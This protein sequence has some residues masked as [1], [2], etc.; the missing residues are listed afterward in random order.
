MNATPPTEPGFRIADW[1]IDPASG[2]VQCGSETRRLFAKSMAVLEYLAR[3]PGQ[4]VSAA[5]LKSNLW[6]GVVVTDGSVYQA[7]A[8]IRRALD[9]DAEPK[10]I[11]TIPRRGY[12]LDAPVSRAPRDEPTGVAADPE[13][14]GDARATGDTAAS[15]LPAAPVRRLWLRSAMLV[16][17]ALFAAV[18]LAAW[19][20]GRAARTPSY[21]VVVLPFTTREDDAAIQGIASSLT[22]EVL[23]ALSRMPGVHAPARHS[24]EAWQHE[25]RGVAALARAAP[26]RWAVEGELRR[27][28]DRIV[29][30]A[31]LSDMRRRTSVWQGSFA[32]AEGE[33]PLV[34]RAVSLAVAAQLP[35][36]S[37]DSR[38]AASMRLGTL[39]AVA[40]ERY[41]LGRHAQAKR[42]PD[43]IRRA[44]TLQ[45]Q[46]IALDPAFALAYAGLADAHLASRYYLARTVPDVA[47][48]VE[49]LL[50]RAFALDPRLPEL[51]A[52]RGVLRTEQFRL[53][54]AIADLTRAAELRPGDADILVRLGAALEYSGKP[55]E[56]LAPFDRA[57]S[58]DPLHFIVH[59]RRC[60]VLQN[61]GRYDDARSA[62]ER[63]MEI[64]PDLPNGHWT[65]GLLDL[66]RGDYDGA[67]RGYGA[68]LARA[69]TRS[70]LH[71]QRGVL[72]LDL[73][74]VAEAR[75]AFERAM[76]AAQP[77]DAYPRLA[78]ARLHVATGNSAGLMEHLRTM[79]L[80]GMAS[81]GDRIDA[82]FLAS[83][84]GDPAPGRQV[85]TEALQD[86]VAAD[87]LT[88]VWSTRWGHADLL[89]LAV[90]AR[91]HGREADGTALASALLVRLEKLESNGHVWHGLHY[92]KAGALAMTG[93]TAE[94]LAELE[95][96]RRLGYRRAWWAARDPALESLRAS[97]EH[98]AWRAR[99][100]ADVRRESE[101]LGALDAS[102]G[103]A[104]AARPA[105]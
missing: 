37:E 96:A 105:R 34:S 88:D 77:G 44:I 52:A 100:E 47:R 26:T 79:P 39:N 10:V 90:L 60:L 51:Y 50:T 3:R 33:L 20:A 62:C 31:R 45:E 83:L 38:R 2:T 12:R 97:A 98:A 13:Q 99:L 81:L 104:R 95:A 76:A 48:S 29:V 14:Q 21:G 87:R 57:A 24:V 28:G 6:R 23:S 85:L 70:D 82:A 17:A 103:L 55:R 8:D 80:D 43:A 16:G 91:D 92:L 64:E 56:A 93:A 101:V 35:S 72:L 73:G 25:H 84:A 19:N 102:Q 61:L 15:A 46:A 9:D 42:T 69:P 41:L 36:G 5:E 59:V 54:E 89:S 65:L 4:V 32:S 67:L 1:V 53:D 78:A 86:E 30:D 94:A 63:A 22:D 49:P 66:A 27:E 68:A 71:A 74:R 11:V 40:Y 75:A 7:I 18:V 58:L